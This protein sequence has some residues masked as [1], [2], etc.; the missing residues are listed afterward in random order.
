M[1]FAQSHKWLISAILSAGINVTSYYSDLVHRLTTRKTS[2]MINRLKIT[3]VALSFLALS[4]G[5]IGSANA[6]LITSFADSS[7]TGATID[8][9]SSYGVAN[10]STISNSLFS[11]TQN[12]GG[13]LAVTDGF[14]GSYSATGRS[15]VSWGGNGVTFNFTQGI[16]AFA[17]MIGGS[18]YNWSAAA[19]DINGISLGLATVSYVTR[20]FILGWS[21]ANIG[22]INFTPTYNDAVLFDDLHYVVASASQESSSVP[23][24]VTLALLGMGLFG[25]GAARRRKANK[26]V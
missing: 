24:P 15:V 19:S 11:M 5:M 13:T 25:M 16:S 12:G 10:V 4:A 26:A 20:G 23:E 21:G 14:S 9:F 18:D 7:L 22:S 17:V 3:S 1:C 2:L 6:G 8:N